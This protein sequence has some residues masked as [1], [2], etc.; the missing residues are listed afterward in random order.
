MVGTCNMGRSKLCDLVMSE[1][2]EMGRQVPR[3]EEW[4]PAKAEPWASMGEHG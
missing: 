1:Q 4:E 3:V 2:V